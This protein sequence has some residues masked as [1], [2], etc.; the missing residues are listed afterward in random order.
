MGSSIYV[1]VYDKAEMELELLITEARTLTLHD[2]ESVDD[3]QKEEKRAKLLRKQE[4]L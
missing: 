3:I 4:H 1:T 2:D